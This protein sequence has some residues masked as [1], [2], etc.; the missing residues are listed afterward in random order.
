MVRFRSEP[1]KVE[2]S[3]ASKTR[4][5]QP[6]FGLTRA[7][8]PSHATPLAVEIAPSQSRTFSAPPSKAAKVEPVKAEKRESASSTPKPLFVRHIKK[9]RTGSVKPVSS[10]IGVITHKRKP[11][12]RVLQWTAQ[13]I[14]SQSSRQK[15]VRIVSI[16]S[17][18]ASRKNIQKFESPMS[19][20]EALAAVAQTGRNDFASLP[21]A[22]PTRIP[23]PLN[24]WVDES[25]DEP[26][27]TDDLGS[28]WSI[29]AA[30]EEIDPVTAAELPVEPRYGLT[31]G[32]YERDPQSDFHKS[33]SAFRALQLP[34]LKKAPSVDEKEWL[35]KS[36]PSQ[37]AVAESEG[38][39][40]VPAVVQTPSSS[41]TPRTPTAVVASVPQASSEVADAEVYVPD[42]VAIEIADT[43]KD[44]DQQAKPEPTLVRPDKPRVPWTKPIDDS[45]SSSVTE[46]KPNDMVTSVPQNSLVAIAAPNVTNQLVKPNPVASQTTQ[47]SQ[48]TQTN[49]RSSLESP[50]NVLVRPSTAAQ[51][52]PDFSVDNNSHP[53][54]A[55]VQ[56]ASPKVNA[57]EVSKPAKVAS[58]PAAEDDQTNVIAENVSPKAAMAIPKARLSAVPSQSAS[59]NPMKIIW[60][61]PG[62]EAAEAASYLPQP[63]DPDVGQLTGTFSTDERADDWLEDNKGHVELFLEPVDRTDKK[64]LDMQDVGYRYRSQEDDPNFSILSKRLRSG[65]YKLHALIFAG[66]TPKL[67]ADIAYHD[68]IWWGY[69]ANIEFHITR[70]DIDHYRTYIQNVPSRS[71]VLNVTLFEGGSGDPEHPYKIPNG[72]VRVAGFPELG[73]FYSDGDGNI[74]IPHV[75]S[76]SELLLE[77][78][79]SGYFDTEKV[80]PIFTSDVYEVVHLVSRDKIGSLPEFFTKR[81][82]D[83][84]NGIIVGR[85]LDDVSHTPKEG[86]SVSLS[87]RKSPPLYIDA[88][89]DLKLSATSSTGLFAFFNIA[90]SFRLISRSEEV[91]PLLMNVKPN[92]AQY[93][94]FG[95]GEERSVHGQI[96]DGLNGVHPEAK[97]RLVG[98]E[99]SEVYTDAQGEFTIS[100]IDLPEGTITLEISAEGYPTTWHTLA[101]DPAERETKHHMFMLDSDLLKDSALDVAR[102]RSMDRSTGAIIGGAEPSLFAH[103]PG[104]FSVELEDAKERK[105][106]S[107]KGPFPW[108]KPSEGNELCLTQENPRFAYYNLAP[109]EYIL[110][111]FDAVH[112]VPR[113]H[114]FYVG[115]DRVS[116][117]IN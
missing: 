53:K 110:K 34:Q 78:S 16:K 17:L 5:V 40:K 25:F 84:N 91:I 36:E 112:Q 12:V 58:T 39:E 79:A 69:K 101:W 28:R 50:T 60:N 107:E 7:P 92:H 54:M 42:T 27:F 41:S 113:T 90:P 9:A 106:I 85:T 26:S 31:L 13:T 38:S 61:R 6:A 63:N 73:V 108:G 103:H 89:P 2:N 3:A 23:E 105:V 46:M 49:S 33:L 19:A 100:H 97:V 48:N 96:F 88:L 30:Q 83:S 115:M 86:E 65:L 114:T 104:C 37:P 117:V 109:G 64:P 81:A 77:V 32:E 99:K 10:Q 67:E 8:V 57:M 47:R 74:R 22:R 62:R 56:K 59:A 71:L 116:M 70:D 52:Q 45:S 21:R 87:F 111:W 18:P 29:S 15:L 55:A 72:T 11:L 102:I 68:M 4:T 1:P 82:Q 43:G 35:A 75:P 94:E 51:S 44:D 66:D 24:Q 95:R 76:R 14:V 93:I 20:L 98:Q 80:V